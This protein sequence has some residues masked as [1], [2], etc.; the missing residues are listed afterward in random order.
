V[1]EV[2]SR[3]P[4]KLPLLE[5]ARLLPQVQAE[6]AA[7]HGIRLL[8]ET[9]AHGISGSHAICHNEIVEAVALPGELV[10]G[11]DSHTCTAG[12]VGA[13]AFGVGSTDMAAAFLTRDVRLKVP[14]SLRVTLRGRL[15]PGVTA[16]D[17]MLHVFRLPELREG[18]AVGRVLEFGGDGIAA[19]V[20][21]ELATLCN[22]AVEAGA[23]TGI[24]E[25]DD[26][27]LS[28]LAALRGRPVETL[29]ARAVRADAR[30]NYRVRIELD[31]G[32]V[33]PMLALPGDP[34][35]A[36]PFSE[37]SARFG[38][39]PIDIAYG[40]TCTGGKRTDMDAY[41]AVLSRAR[42]QGR[43]VAAT[44][45][46]YLQLGSQRVLEHARE[47]EYLGLFETVG[48]RVLGPACGACIGAGPGTS[49]RSSQVSISA[50]SRNFPGRS[51]PGAVYLA[52]PYVVAAS[53][54]AGFITDPGGL[55][56]GDI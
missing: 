23:F 51:G 43:T 15:R 27:R 10:I 11:T 31:L 21:D 2:L 56:G 16:K 22:M 50:G 55:F 7:R 37:F 19:L 47:R 41:A 12:A 32:T 48:A 52:N 42:D 25:L 6:F 5:Q 40:G 3:D 46:L 13:F 30:A 9:T 54:I 29:R 1:D 45:E 26:V 18:V 36:L 49:S 24:V 20:L 53:A 44:V 38:R 39:I 14:E 33:E 34:R 17:V 35:N 28:E 8:G 4:K